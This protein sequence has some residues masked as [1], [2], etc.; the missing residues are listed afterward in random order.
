MV[1]VVSSIN[2]LSVESVDLEILM[3][4]RRLKL[5][6]LVDQCGKVGLYEGS[7]VEVGNEVLKCRI[8]LLL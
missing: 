5:S 4:I 3:S 1:V 7:R 8:G 2:W 6:R